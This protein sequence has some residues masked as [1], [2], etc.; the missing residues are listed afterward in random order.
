MSPSDRPV[1]AAHSDP[2]A[3]RLAAAKGGYVVPAAR[4]IPEEARADVARALKDRSEWSL[5]VE[6]A[7]L[8]TW[9]AYADEA[10]DALRPHLARLLVGAL[11]GEEAVV[12]RMARAFPEYG[13]DEE[14]AEAALRSLM[15]DTPDA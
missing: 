9:N 10:I 3:R 11:G 5:Q 6:D 4:E 7:P 8:A 15:E 2:A 12:E 13:T 1:P 14:C